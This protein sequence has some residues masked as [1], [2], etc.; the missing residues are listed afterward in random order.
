MDQFKLK[1]GHFRTLTTAAHGAGST[2]G[3]QVWKRSSP[4]ALIQM[5]MV[6]GILS[7]QIDE[8]KFVTTDTL[9]AYLLKHAGGGGSGARFWDSGKG[10][11]LF[12]EN[13]VTSVTVE[14]S[15]PDY[16]EVMPYSN[17]DAA[18]KDDRCFAVFVKEGVQHGQYDLLGTIK[19][20]ATLKPGSFSDNPTNIITSDTICLYAA[21][22]Y[23]G[24]PPVVNGI[25]TQL[26]FG[27]K[28]VHLQW[29]DVGGETSYKIQRRLNGGTWYDL[30]NPAANQTVYVDTTVVSG[31]YQYQIKS[32]NSYGSSAYVTSAQVGVS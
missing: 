11:T 17:V 26:L 2:L 1:L 32:V 23:S 14:V 15:R 3:Q 18:C 7:A 4:N 6:N 27:P 9:F 25:N 5:A 10:L 31:A 13:C 16:V 19:M 29:Q 30:V 21:E 28:R 8:I 12:I 22:A 20:T 24:L